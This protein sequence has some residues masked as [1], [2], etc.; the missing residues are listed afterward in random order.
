MAALTLYCPHLYAMLSL[1]KRTEGAE[2]LSGRLHLKLEQTP[3]A[4]PIAIAEGKPVGLRM[5]LDQQKRAAILLLL[6]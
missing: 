5:P 6:Q 2:L 3:M 4:I 1:S